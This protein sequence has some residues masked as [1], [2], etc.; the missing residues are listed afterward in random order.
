MTYFDYEVCPDCGHQMIYGGE[1][2]ECAARIAR[3]TGVDQ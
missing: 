3:T 2:S 1:C